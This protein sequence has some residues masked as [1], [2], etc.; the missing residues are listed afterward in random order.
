MSADMPQM[1]KRKKHERA[2]KARQPAEKQRN[3]LRVVPPDLKDEDTQEATPKLLIICLDSASM[4]NSA[5]SIPILIKVRDVSQVGQ[6]N[7][8]DERLPL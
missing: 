6:T 8:L 5:L 3:T 2:G 7:G 1:A 4:A